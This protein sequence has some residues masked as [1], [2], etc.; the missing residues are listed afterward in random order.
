MF[1]FIKVSQFDFALRKNTR[2]YFISLKLALRRF[3][4]FLHVFSFCAHKLT[5]SFEAS[6]ITEVLVKYVVRFSLT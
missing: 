6:F 1:V 4:H 2:L 3:V 5:H